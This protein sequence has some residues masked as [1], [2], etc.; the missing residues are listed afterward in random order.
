M[1][2]RTVQGEGTMSPEDNRTVTV[3]GAAAFEAWRWRT[4]AEMADDDPPDRGE[5]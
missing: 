1:D 2:L 5:W 3:S 4:P